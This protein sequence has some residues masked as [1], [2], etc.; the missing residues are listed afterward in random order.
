MIR[1]LLLSAMLVF[2]ASAHGPWPYDCC[3][4]ND[5]AE[6]DARHIREIGDQVHIVIPPGI[7][8]M[9]PA[10]GRPPFVGTVAR[11]SLRKP[12]S[13][14]WGVCISATGSLLCVF[15]PSAGT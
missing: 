4:N 15:P 14:E 8:P 5:C 7:H 13:G 10:D 12:V 11:S 3:A 6:V 1:S 2:P 9:W